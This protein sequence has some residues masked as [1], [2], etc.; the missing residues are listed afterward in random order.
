MADFLLGLDY[1]TG[2]AKACIINSEGE[3][4]GYAFEEYPIFHDKPG[5]SEHDAM[6]YW[7]AACRLIKQCLAQSRVDPVEIRGMG[8][9]SA[10]PSMV[11]IDKDNQPI[12]RAYNLMDRRAK[13][14]VEWLKVVVGEERL[15][16]FTANRLEDHPAIVN[17]L[18]E[19]NNRPD[20]FKKIHKA[21]T[22]DGFVTLKLTEQTVVN[23]PGAPFYGV[24]RILDRTFDS[25]IL[26][27]IGIDPAIF[28][29]LVDCEEIAGEVTAE[30]AEE[31]GLVP[32]IPVVTQVDF[33]ASCIAAG[34]I[35]PGD[36]MSNLGTVGNFGVIFTDPDF[37]FSPAGLLM[38]NLAFSIDSKKNFM[39]IP[40][41]IT[42][43]QSLRYIR[44]N[45]SHLELEM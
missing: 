17:L 4:L 43:G 38:I 42:G 35:E 16:Q 20:S 40:S 23:Y 12:H 25:T 22:I 19:R 9:S 27:E 26:E 14:E 5:W 37:M 3:V 11:M 2:G 45:F 41:T 7:E 13:A 36:I 28:P 33:N 29:D 1:G 18:W 21:L 30:A 10:L 31:T 24:Y 44:D 39:T 32:G 34:V 6:G 15:M 8:V